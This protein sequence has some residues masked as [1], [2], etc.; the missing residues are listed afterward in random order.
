MISV[1][2]AD[3]NEKIKRSTEGVQTENTILAVTLATIL[4]VVIL[5]IFAANS[6]SKPI[7]ELTRVAN[8]ISDGNVDVEIP[9]IKTKDEI[10]DLGES[11]KAVLAAV[12]FFRETLGMNEDE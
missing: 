2:I 4:V 7:R 11:M 8:V 10:Y 6:I 12:D 9:V 1:K 3:A 5:G